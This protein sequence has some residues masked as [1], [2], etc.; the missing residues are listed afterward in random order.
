MQLVCEGCGLQGKSDSRRR[1]FCSFECYNRHRWISK[2]E[3]DVLA[4][5]ESLGF[6]IERQARRG[7]WTFDGAIV[8]TNA[9]IEA[10]GA[11]WHSL[12]VAVER[13]AKKDQWC[14]DNGYRLLRVPEKAFRANPIATVWQLALF[15]EAEGLTVELVPSS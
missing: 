4:V 3:K 6:T 12:P 2:L 1:R 9:L 5:F 13:D 14:K 7:R 10:D 11:Y 15:A 8:G